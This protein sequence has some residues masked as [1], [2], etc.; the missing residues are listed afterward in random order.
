MPLCM[1]SFIL[2]EYVMERILLI[3]GFMDEVTNVHRYNLFKT[4][5]LHMFCKLYFQFKHNP[6]SY[7]EFSLFRFIYF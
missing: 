7:K 4:N 1:M 6:G 5:F 3:A 2:A